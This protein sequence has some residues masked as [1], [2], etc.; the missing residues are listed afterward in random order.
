LPKP[1]LTTNRS[2]IINNAG[3][4]YSYS[5]NILALKEAIN[6]KR[7]SIAFVGTPCQ[8]RAIRKLEMVGLKKYAGPLA[9]SIGLMCSECFHYEGLVKKHIQGKLGIDPRDVRKMNIKGKMLVQT[10][11]TVVT[12]P[13]AEAKEY[14][15]RSCTFCNDFSSEL[16][17]I[18]AGGLGLEG[19]TF[20]VVR[21]EKGDRLLSGVMESGF[22]DTEPLEKDSSALNLL[23]RL[24][25]KKRK[26]Q[27]S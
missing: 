3:T 13:L 23:A 9:M 16:A 27:G 2:A 11:D 5:P 19:Y 12:I 15:R 14:A 10:G 26:Q 24:S 1:I 18:S 4:R 25:N 17:D 21:T 8:I 22:L 7:E 6:Q 20:T